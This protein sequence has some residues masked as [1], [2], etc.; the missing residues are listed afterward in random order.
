M[1]S[2]ITETAVDAPGDAPSNA[3]NVPSSEVITSV[4]NCNVPLPFSSVSLIT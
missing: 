1:M 2:N 4:P 3:A